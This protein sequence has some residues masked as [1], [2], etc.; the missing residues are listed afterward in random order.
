LRDKVVGP[1]VVVGVVGG[2]RSHSRSIQVLC[3]L[4]LCTTLAAMAQVLPTLNGAC[5][6][7]PA[8][9][10]SCN[11]LSAVTARPDKK[12]ENGKTRLFV[13]HYTLAP[14]DDWQRRLT[15]VSHVVLLSPWSFLR[16]ERLW[17]PREGSLRSTGY[18]LVKS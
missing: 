8:G 12:T 14:G 1:P 5:S 9:L 10:E 18:S 4:A 16:K 7:S 15:K 6:V 2:V 17:H 13:T 3:L 11:W